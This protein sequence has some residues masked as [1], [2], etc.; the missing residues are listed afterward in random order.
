MSKL[1]DITGHLVS[2][3]YQDM[4]GVIAHKKGYQLRHQELVKKF[5]TEF[6]ALMLELIS[7]THYLNEDGYQCDEDELRKKVEEL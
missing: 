1:D 7:E 4:E 2:T 6:K 3:A 5:G